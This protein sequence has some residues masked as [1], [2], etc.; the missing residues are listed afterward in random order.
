[1]N[2]KSPQKLLPVSQWIRSL[3]LSN[4]I[5][6]GSVSLIMILLSFLLFAG[7]NFVF[8]VLDVQVGLQTDM[9][10]QKI[11]SLSQEAAE[12]LDELT[13]DVTITIVQEE[14][15]F[16]AKTIQALQN[17]DLAS[18]KIT[19]QYIN[20]ELNPGFAEMFRNES[21]TD[22][23]IIISCGNKYQILE[24][25]D[26]YYISTTGSVTGLRTDQKLCSAIAFVSAEEQPTLGVIVGH[27]SA[28]PGELMQLCTGINRDVEELT[29]LL[30][31]IPEK[32]DILI[33][34]EP[35]VDFAPEEI[36]KLDDWMLEGNK[37]IVIIMD[38]QTGS[39][40]VLESYL[41]EWGL[42]PQSSIVIDGE[43]YWGGNESYLLAGY[44]KAS[45]IGQSALD[46]KLSLAMPL[47]RPIELNAQNNNL[48]NC[49]QF[50]VVKSFDS[51]YSKKL[52]D[53]NSGR[54]NSLE[55]S[56]NDQTGSF[57]LGA[58]STKLLANVG[59]QNISS[60]LFLYGSAR[61]ADDSML[62]S[63]VL[64]N[65]TVLMDSLL[66]D[67]QKTDSMN[68]PIVALKSYSME[69]TGTEAKLIRAITMYFIPLGLCMAGAVIWIRRK[70]R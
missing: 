15:G 41:A 39:L 5:K 49:E 22:T 26:L 28:M 13:Q 30:D 68:I 24:E 67:K 62:V 20:L 40:P 11:Y 48:S 29:L 65:R 25:R 52:E 57:V 4:K 16:D 33:L 55:K 35:T 3:T 8:Q 36:K 27:G 47:C 23:S 38:A 42:E 19:Y 50:P 45:G 63:T 66:Y 32:A 6:Y 37:N 44:S 1:M 58:G 61:M 51:A 60:T 9:T 59:G 43:H 56:E 7:I 31:Q 10:T 2:K 69:M 64:G 53:G 18:D 17:F 54:I 34:Y 21:I 70:K 46:S 14:S 12:Y